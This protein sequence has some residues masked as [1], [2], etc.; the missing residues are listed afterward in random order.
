MFHVGNYTMA[1]PRHVQV[2]HKACFS[3]G[4]CKRPLDRLRLVKV[5]LFHITYNFLYICCSKFVRTYK[6]A[7]IFVSLNVYKLPEILVSLYVRT[8]F[9]EFLE[10]CTLWLKSLMPMA[11][12][13]SVSAC[14]TPEKDIFCRGCYGW[15]HFHL[16]LGKCIQKKGKIV[17]R[18]EVWGTWLWVCWRGRRSS[19]WRFVSKSFK[20][21]SI[22]RK[23]DEKMRGFLQTRDLL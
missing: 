9:P 12:N 18:K 16:I 1:H 21:L 8:N 11:L 2:Y 14:D 5:V 23:Q 7:V 20:F 19:D 4:N 17:P 6:L 13:F 3:C 10:V 15:L 22:W